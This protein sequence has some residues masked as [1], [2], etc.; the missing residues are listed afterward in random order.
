MDEQ[1]N[2]FDCIVELCE[3]AQ[4]AKDNAGLAK[5]DCMDGCIM[6]CQYMI[7]KALTHP[8]NTSLSVQ[9]WGTREGMDED[10]PV[11]AQG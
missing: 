6:R 2:L 9:N 4:N 11:E 3:Y 1:V 5:K 8:H 7:G 10:A